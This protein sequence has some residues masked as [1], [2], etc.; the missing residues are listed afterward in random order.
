M[1][2][3][4]G[5]RLLRDAGLAVTP[6][7]PLTR[8][9]AARNGFAELAGKLGLPLF[10]KPANQGSSVG[11]SKVSDEVQYTAAVELALGFDE[12]VLVESGVSGCD[13]VDQGAAYHCGCAGLITSCKKGP[14]VR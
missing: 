4:I 14:A 9:T 11:V 10:V 5:K 6:F 12:K 2:K 8:A 3:D 7:V 1:D 13:S